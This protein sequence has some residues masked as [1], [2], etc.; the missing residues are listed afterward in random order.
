M[1]TTSL[2]TSPHLTSLHPPSGHRRCCPVDTASGTEFII[3]RFTS[4][5]RAGAPAARCFVSASAAAEEDPRIDQIVNSQASAGGWQVA[6][7]PSAIDDANTDAGTGEGGGGS[8]PPPPPPLPPLAYSA[9]AANA[10]AAAADAHGSAVAGDGGGDGGGGGGGGGW[11]RGQQQ[12]I[13][14]HATGGNVVDLKHNAM[15]ESCGC[16]TGQ[17]VGDGDGGGG[18]GGTPSSDAATRSSPSLS[19][20]LSP[21][22]QPQWQP[23]PVQLAGQ[24]QRRTPVGRRLGLLLVVTCLGGYAAGSSS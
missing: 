15:L 14:L 2:A 24:Q 20:P 13:W 6:A 10:S 8:Q 18:G 11:Q 5:S 7:A 16:T 22:Q 21:P 23:P 1:R 19:S 4:D 17:G 12:T 3:L 9:G